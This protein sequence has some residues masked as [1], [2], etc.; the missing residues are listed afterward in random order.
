MGREGGKGWEGGMVGGDREGWWLEGR[1]GGRE[2]VTGREREGEGRRE[3]EHNSVQRSNF[4]LASVHSSHVNT[5]SFLPREENVFLL[6]T[7]P[8]APPSS[9][10][11]YKGRGRG[12]CI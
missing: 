2:G 6:Q 9:Y 1:E 7:L 12:S 4:T 5:S 11:C 8:A 3:G 10:R